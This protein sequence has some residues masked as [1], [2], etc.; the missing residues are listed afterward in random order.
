MGV[1]DQLRQAIV[2][3]N[4]THYRIWK[5]S[6]VNSRVIDRFVAGDVDI[7]G[8]TLDKLCDHLGLELCR[9]KGQT[10]KKQPAKKRAT[11]DKQK[12]KKRLS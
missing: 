5:E 6:D 11:T 8:T 3:S 12:R 9:K 2:A 1:T 4:E 10:A 7:R